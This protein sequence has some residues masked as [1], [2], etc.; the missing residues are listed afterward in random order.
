V[1]PGVVIHH[2]EVHLDVAGDE[3]E[4]AFAQLFERHIRRWDRARCEAAARARLAASDRRLLPRESGEREG[5]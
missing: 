1:K 4:V 3:E 2:L 5:S